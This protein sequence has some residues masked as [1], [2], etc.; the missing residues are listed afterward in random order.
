MRIQAA[1]LLALIPPFFAYAQTYTISTVAGGGVG[2]GGPGTTAVISNPGAGLALDSTGN[3]Y[4]ADAGHNR[5][6]KVDAVTGNISTVAGSG[7][8]G[9]SWDGGLAINASLASPGGVEVD[10]AGNLYIADTN[11]NRVRKVDA[12]TGNI[13]TLAGNGNATTFF[14]NGDGSSAAAASLNSPSAVAVDSAGNVYIADT[15]DNLIR[16][17]VKATGIIT[18][19]VVKVNGVTVDR[20]AGVALDP[21]GN[22]FIVD[23]SGL[24]WKVVTGTGAV[25]IVAGNGMDG[26]SGDGGPAT[27]AIFDLPTGLAVDSSG[28]IYVADNGNGRIRQIAVATGII[29]TVAGNGM[30]GFSGDGGA[31]TNASFF[32]PVG[33]ATDSSGNLYIVDLGNQCIRKV[34]AATG[35]ITTIVGDGLGLYGGDGGPATSAYLASPRGVALDVSG[36]LYIADYEGERIRQ[37]AAATDIIETVAGNGTYADT[38]DGG[39]ATSAGL[40]QP[41]GV[42]ADS[43]GNLYFSEYYGNRVRKVAAATGIITTVAGNGKPSFSGDG[44]LATSASLSLPFDVTVDGAGNL[45]IADFGNNRIRK[46]AASTGIITTFAGNGAV[47]FSGD[48][49]AAASASLNEPYSVA[50]DASANLLLCRL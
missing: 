18:T 8:Y 12:V 35:V 28:N 30:V 29:T 9:Y 43:A 14:Y 24:I 27:S 22:L 44:G 16:K 23:G 38:G 13:S 20:P 21:S 19:V 10:S 45:Y 7:A 1:V 15:G 2:D 32:N 41:S 26:F 42:A 33:V 3:L 5:I 6:R 46:V 11:N 40:F 49:G 39:A 48:G 31:A 4:I 17:V 36:N 34:T 25:T 47:G 37:V 50:V